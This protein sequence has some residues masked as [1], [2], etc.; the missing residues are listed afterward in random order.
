MAQPKVFGFDTGLLCH[1]RGWD[2]LRPEDC[3]ALWEHLVLDTLIA[4]GTPKIHFWRDKQQR[5]V[6]FVVP[7]NRDTVDA[8]EYKWQPE[9]FETRGLSA[10]RGQS[11]THRPGPPRFQGRRFNNPQNPGSVMTF[12]WMLPPIFAPTGWM[13]LP[14]PIRTTARSLSG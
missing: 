1:A 13:T 9:S 5:E 14:C 7:R 2:H 6:D 12:F 10:S 8:I 4:C 3:G 11:P